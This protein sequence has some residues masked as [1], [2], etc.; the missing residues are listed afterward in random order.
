MNDSR[1]PAVGQEQTTDV[2]Q[3]LDYLYARRQSGSH[4]RHHDSSETVP[5]KTAP[6]PRPPQATDSLGTGATYCTVVPDAPSDS[7]SWEGRR[8]TMCAYPRILPTSCRKEPTHV[9]NHGVVW[10]DP[11][12]RRDVSCRVQLHLGRVQARTQ[13]NVESDNAQRGL[14]P[15]PSTRRAVRALGQNDLITCGKEALK[16][17]RKANQ[18][19][20]S[21]H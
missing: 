11:Q 12:L 8:P 15:R 2:R 4:S 7:K 3:Y 5:T 10:S 1:A 19:Q 13:Q 18:G 16:I 21:R 6:A 14:Q 9:Q 17:I 20:A